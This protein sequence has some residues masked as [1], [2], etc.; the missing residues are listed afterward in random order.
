MLLSLN[1][2]LYLLTLL[3]GVLLISLY[4]F[5]SKGGILELNPAF[6]LKT[7][8]NNFRDLLLVCI[9]GAALGGCSYLQS[10]TSFGISGLLTFLCLPAFI[11][12]KSPI[13]TVQVLLYGWTSLYGFSDSISLLL[14]R[15]IGKKKNPS[16]L[17]KYLIISALVSSIVLSISALLGNFRTL[18]FSFPKS[19]LLLPSIVG[20]PLI[21]YMKYQGEMRPSFVAFSLSASSL[22][23]AL[24]GKLQP[25]F[26]TLGLFIGLIFLIK[27][28]NS[29]ILP[30]E[31]IDRENPF[32]LINSVRRYSRKRLVLSALF[33][34]LTASFSNIFF[35]I[36]L[37]GLLAIA[38]KEL[39]FYFFI[40]SL[41]RA[42]V[43][44]VHRAKVLLD[45]GDIENCILMVL[46]WFIRLLSKSLEMRPYELRS[47][48]DPQR[49]GVRRLIWAVLNPPE[50]NRNDAE[51]ILLILE[52]MLCHD[53]KV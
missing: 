22:V 51:E 13:S 49:E 9:L 52:S 44:E 26:V 24:L 25:I 37:A 48:C 43:E 34:V 28:S 42:G 12:L 21:G 53:E 20:M 41:R 11:D 38:L 4:L 30:D 5:S 31:I 8:Y 6:Q 15:Y 27:V 14:A 29:L 50:G 47:L 19:Y 46:P 18:Y 3:Y 40:R 45:S 7:S 39:S 1:R 16:S 17:L 23:F 32:D 35:L 2:I 36:S 33:T 10:I